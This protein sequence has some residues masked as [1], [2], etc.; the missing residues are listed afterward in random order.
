MLGHDGPPTSYW[1][2][3]LV[4][5]EPLHRCPVRTTQLADQKL[6]QELEMFRFEIYPFWKKGHFPRAGGAG[7]QD[8]RQLAM[9]REL[10]LVGEIVKDRY[11]ELRGETD[12][13]DSV[14][15]NG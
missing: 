9:I 15:G 2:E 10:D 1:R 13:E 6:V 5:G 7:D 11:R 14:D 12:G 8:A 3:N 4:N